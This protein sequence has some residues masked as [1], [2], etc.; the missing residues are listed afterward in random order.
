MTPKITLISHSEFPDNDP[1]VRWLL[2]QE[3][4]T[5]QVILTQGAE[6]HLCHRLAEVLPHVKGELFCWLEPGCE[7]Q[8]PEWLTCLYDVWCNAHVDLLGVRGMAEISLHTLQSRQGSESVQLSRVIGGARIASGSVQEITVEPVLALGPGMLMGAVS[9]LQPWVQGVGSLLKADNVI[10]FTLQSRLFAGMRLGVAQ[11][12]PLLEKTSPV[13]WAGYEQLKAVAGFLPLSRQGFEIWHR[14]LTA[15]SSIQ[16]E[17]V[18]WLAE[19]SM[20]SRWTRFE[21]RGTGRLLLRGGTLDAIV[22]DV[23]I[24][25]NPGDIWWMLGSGTGN[26]INE[27]LAIPD[28]C[29]HVLEPEA[30]LLCHLLSRFDWSN[31]IRQRRLHLHAWDARHPLWKQLSARHLMAGFQAELEASQGPVY[32]TAGGSY[33]LNES[34]LKDVERGLHRMWMRLRECMHWKSLRKEEFDVTVVSPQCAIFKD[35]AESFHRMGYK[36]RLLNVSDGTVPL[37]WQKDSQQV[38]NLLQHGSTL[39]LFRNRSLLESDTWQEPMPISPGDQ[40]TWVSWW[41]DL[42]N[43][44]SLIEQ[45]I[46]SQASPALGF[47]RAMLNSLPKGSEWLPPAARTQFCLLDPVAEQVRHEVSFVGQSRWNLVRTQLAILRALVPDYLPA[48]KALCENWRWQGSAI[49]LHQQLELDTPWMQ[50]VIDRLSEASPA[51][52]YYLDYVW[53]MAFSGVFRMASVESLIREGVP[54]A[55]YGDAEW[56]VSGIVPEKLFA[57]SLSL[58]DLPTVYRQSRINLNLNF[59]QVSS[60]VNPKVLDIS[61]C[62][63]MVLTDHRNELDELF[64]YPDQRPASFGSLEELP[65]RVRTLLQ[66]DTRQIG[67]QCGEWVR[68]RHTLQHRAAWLADRYRLRSRL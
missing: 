52:A 43:V 58:A 29:L 66:A 60:T 27:T 39:T 13:G 7:I 42:P 50:L 6:D 30:A 17:L 15:L 23:F 57:G 40:D 48:G 25:S 11:N 35:L 10:T 65:E 14:N 16:P 36:T 64:P 67:A 22:A 18:T 51:K 53:R 32:F 2:A 54:L 61:A 28:T 49:A 68:A 9:T 45:G 55:V 5:V 4:P 31:A 63:G 44:A 59:M 24:K 1:A 38:L 34:S 46:P 62:N 56:L 3:S 26:A 12:F 37:T 33:Y 41:W 19:E 20:N 47:A 8:H 21:S